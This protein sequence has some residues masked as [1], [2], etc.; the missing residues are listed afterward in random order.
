MDSTLYHPTLASDQAY[1]NAA[2]R[3]GIA[4]GCLASLICF[5]ITRRNEL[6]RV[7]GQAKIRLRQKHAGRIHG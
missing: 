6:L 7:R 2:L 3:R 1:R 5:A 4:G